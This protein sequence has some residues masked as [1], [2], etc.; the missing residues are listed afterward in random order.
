MQQGDEPL[1]G[2]VV[3]V[4]AEPAALAVARLDDPRARLA[5]GLDA[6]PQLDLEAVVLDRQRGASA[7]RQQRGSPR[8]RGVHEHADALPA[9]TSSVATVPSPPGGSANGRPSRPT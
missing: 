7:R 2:A 5:Q 8:A 4:A 3:E 1:L 9:V 6:R